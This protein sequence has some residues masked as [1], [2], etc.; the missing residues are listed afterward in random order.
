MIRYSLENNSFLL[1]QLFSNQVSLVCTPLIPYSVKNNYFLLLQI[2]SNQVSLGCSRINEVLTIWKGS[3]YNFVYKHL[4][5]LPESLTE[6]HQLPFLPRCFW[7][8]SQK[9]GHDPASRLATCSQ[10]IK[11]QKLSW[12]SITNLWTF[13]NR[14]S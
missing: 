12:Q 8:E 13:S 9:F 3:S 7:C 4:L 11:V 5:G 14:K 2:L 1:L 6:S 10:V